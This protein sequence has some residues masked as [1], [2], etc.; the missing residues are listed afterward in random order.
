MVD[1]HVF[2]LQRI[3]GHL[4]SDKCKQDRAMDY[5]EALTFAVVGGMT[6]DAIR[7]RRE[8][9]PWHSELEEQLDP[10]KDMAEHVCLVGIDQ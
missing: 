7:G 9:E 5:V 8:C 4:D 2:T 10:S 1:P 3:R 6:G